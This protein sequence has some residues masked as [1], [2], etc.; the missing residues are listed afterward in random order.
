MANDYTVKILTSHMG[1]SS[2]C[3]DVDFVNLNIK[4]PNIKSA[5]IQIGD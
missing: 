2:D 4:N 5:S 3:L 1:V